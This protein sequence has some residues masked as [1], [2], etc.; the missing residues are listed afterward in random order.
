MGVCSGRLKKG[1]GGCSVWAQPENG[2]LM[3]GPNSKKGVLG[4]AA[5]PPQVRHWGVFA[6]QLCLNSRGGYTG[7]YRGPLE[8]DSSFCTINCVIHV[9]KTYIDIYICKHNIRTVSVS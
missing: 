6:I 1:G 3:C 5:P 7:L 8:I 9:V 2:V 4:A